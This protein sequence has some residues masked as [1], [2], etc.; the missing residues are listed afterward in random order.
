[1]ALWTHCSRGKKS[2]WRIWG[3]RYPVHFMS[4]SGEVGV[5]LKNDHLPTIEMLAPSLRETDQQPFGIVRS[6]HCVAFQLQGPLCGWETVRQRWRL[7]S[8]S[9]VNGQDS[10][11]VIKQHAWPTGNP[12]CL[13]YVL[14]ATCREHSGLCYSFLY[15]Q[16]YGL[17]L[18]WDAIMPLI[19]RCWSAV[20][21]L[22]HYYYLKDQFYL[23]V[24][25]L[26]TS[27]LIPLTLV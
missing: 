20:V 11:Q 21:L 18:S 24:S 17:R 7:C 15:G 1:M 25:F 12:T 22:R 8:C 23:Q 14:G 4:Q 19:W 10:L 13:T 16:G 26:T 3:K 2:R 27:V 6:V 9:F 5:A